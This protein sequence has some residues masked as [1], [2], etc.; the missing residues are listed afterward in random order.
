MDQRRRSRQPAGIAVELR[1]SADSF[2]SRKGQS[3]T[4]HAGGTPQHPRKQLSS[5]PL[6]RHR[7]WGNI[8][9]GTQPAAGLCTTSLSPGIV[10]GT[11]KTRQATQRADFA[12][13]SSRSVTTGATIGRHHRA[14]DCCASGLRGPTASVPSVASL[15]T[16][17]SGSAPCSADALPPCVRISRAAA[18]ARYNRRHCPAQGC[19]VGAH[20]GELQEQTATTSLDASLRTQCIGSATYSAGHALQSRR[21]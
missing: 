17:H 9:M 2:G 7:I 11:L 15:S 18:P 21:P 6:W 1:V 8:A 12:G 10:G 14:P 5:V 20:A 13:C 16:Q 3:R 4:W 19:C